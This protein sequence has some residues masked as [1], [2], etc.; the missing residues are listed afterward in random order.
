MNGKVGIGE[1]FA[2]S[3]QAAQ[4]ALGSQAQ[5]VTRPHPS[6][7]LGAKISLDEVARRVRDGRNDPRVRGWAGRAIVRAGN[8]T[9]IVGRAQALLDALRSQTAY[10]PDPV[11]T[12]LIAKAS[13][14]L[15]LDNLGL[16]LPAADCDD[17]VVAFGAAAMSIGIAVRVVGQAFGTSMATHVID[18]IEDERSNWIRVDPASQYPVGGFFKATNEWWIDPL[19]SGSI[20]MKGDPGSGDYIGIGTVAATP[21]DRRL[22]RM[23]ARLSGAS[24]QAQPAPGTPRSGASPKAQPG[25]VRQTA[26][27]NMP[28][29]TSAQQP[30]PRSPGTGAW[31]GGEAP[32]PV[33]FRLQTNE[34]GFE[35]VFQDQFAGTNEGGYEPP[36]GKNPVFDVDWDDIERCWGD[37][38]GACSVALGAAGRQFALGQGISPA[39]FDAITK[40]VQA[41]IFA[42]ESSKNNLAASLDVLTQARMLLSP[43]SFFDPEPSTPVVDIAS[44]PGNGTWAQRMDVVATQLWELADHLVTIGKS[45]L[46]GAR[47]IVVDPNAQQ[48]A[49]Q[50]KPDDPWGL[51][52]VVQSAE[53]Y[54]F[55]FLDDAGNIISGLSSQDGSALTASQ[56][57][58]AI[59]KAKAQRGTGAVALAPVIII[60]AVVIGVSLIAYYAYSKYC[61]QADT[62]ARMARDKTV[63][64]CIAKGNCPPALLQQVKAADVAYENAKTENEKAD[65]F[66][67]AASSVADVFMW[68]AIGGITIAGIVAVT[69]LLKSAASH[70][71]SEEIS[72]RA[73]RAGYKPKKKYTGPAHT[74]IYREIEIHVHQYTSG[75]KGVAYIWRPSEDLRLDPSGVRA[76]I[77]FREHGRDVDSVVRKLR[78]DIDNYLASA[79]EDTASTYATKVRNELLKYGMS[80]HTANCVMHDFHK[81]ITSQQKR[82]VPPS[83]VAYTLSKHPDVAQRC[84][85]P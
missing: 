79:H 59:N 1:G 43:D 45:A 51:M 28:Q 64:D 67:K 80:T 42:L 10:V 78:A 4:K 85:L 3:V 7:A 77:L 57:Q 14:T 48:I 34:A 53:G 31:T 6:G 13:T 52:A 2:P 44:F 68:L 40:E 84:S 74:E 47:E 36:Y 41:A 63:T 81:F 23:R 17:L 65:P 82:R 58:D 20:G 49:I 62:A 24:A 39:N 19:K 60:G 18:A 16:C 83:N 25:G 27:S 29:P 30:K 75:F 12:E 15:C 5:I 46:Q 38:S 9:T 8:P 76:Q 72:R 70:H 66:A 61:A 26:P 33:P 22:E 73:R 11:G 50:A 56:V 35:P 71:A 54:I 55:A 32:Q 69:P 21:I 37:D